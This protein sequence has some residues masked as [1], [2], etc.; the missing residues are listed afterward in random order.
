MDPA[1]GG[2]IRAWNGWRRAPPGRGTPD[3]GKIGAVHVARPQ[4]RN[5]KESRSSPMTLSTPI[6]VGEPHVFGEPSYGRDTDAD[7]TDG[8]SFPALI[9]SGGFSDIKSVHKRR[10]NAGAVCRQGDRAAR[11]DRRMSE[12]G[13]T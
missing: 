6:V 4:R 3:R 12:T 11:T 13:P 10:R 8:A 2:D 7:G 5:E 1:H 9:A